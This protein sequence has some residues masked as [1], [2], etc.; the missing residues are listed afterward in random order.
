MTLEQFKVV[1]PYGAY[2]FSVPESFYL[3]STW[4]WEWEGNKI[5]ML[6]VPKN[7]YGYFFKEEIIAQLCLQGLKVKDCR[8]GYIG[9][10]FPEGKT[11]Y[12]IFWSKY[13]N[14]YFIYFYK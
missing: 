3:E 1:L 9:I 10:M 13:F 7:S 12:H 14:H 4:E 2:E 8:D 5:L 11:E 6:R